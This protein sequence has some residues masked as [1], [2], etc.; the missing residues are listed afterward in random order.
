MPRFSIIIPVYNRI[1]EVRDLMESLAHQSCKDFEVVIVEDGSSAPCKEVVEE[2]TNQVN[3]SYYYKE[4]EGVQH[5]I[6]PGKDG[7]IYLDEYRELIA[8]ALGVKEDKN[9]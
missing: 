8:K 2:Y 1:D 3:A 5:K 4:N 6:I 9:E 7:K